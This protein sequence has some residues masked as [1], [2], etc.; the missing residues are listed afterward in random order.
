MST[1]IDFSASIPSAAKIKSAGHVGAVMYISPARD[2]WMGAKPVYRSTIDDFDAHGLQAAFVWQFGAGTALA[3]DV[4]RGWDGGVADAKAAQEHLTSIRCAGHP[5]FFA[6]DFDISLIQWN[7]IAAQYF[8]GAASVLG[9]QRVGIYGHSRVIHW[10]MEDDVVA[11]VE[12]GRVLGWQTRSW[13][14]GVIARDY[15]VLYQRIHN[16][17]GPD[18]VQIDVN[19]VLYPEWG[20]RALD[21]YQRPA[22]D[23]DNLPRVDKTRWMNK[24]Y[25]PGRSGRTIKKI[26]RHHMAGIGDVDTC[27]NW[28][29]SR[30]A[31]AHYAVQDDHVG[32][33]VRDEDTAWSNAN[34]VS[35]QESITIE[36]SNSAGAASDWPISD[37]TIHRGAE[38]AAE[39]CLKHNLGR[40]QYGVN[41]DD[42]RDHF[43]TSCPHHL[44]AGGKYHDQWMSHAQAH[45]DALT[46]VTVTASEP[47]FL[48][49]LMSQQVKS[50]INP[51]KSF[52]AATALGLID[53]S[54]WRQEVLGEALLHALGLDVE[55]ILAAAIEAD[56]TGGNRT[57][58]IR[59]ALNLKEQ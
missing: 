40:P 56:N 35:N 24:H 37:A 22:V 55:G 51:E 38:L 25:T 32:Q 14:S 13:S 49:E 9:K 27:W 53:A 23:V 19:D 29:Q 31:S 57:Q 6:V 21:S 17:P 7:N 20:W 58:A 44:A 10:A 47:T 3:S 36:H 54:S 30:A 16:A 4:M 45:Y 2:E 1:V 8:K 26:T 50:F 28:W 34:S 5:V 18:G 52:P 33:L 41:I 43:A 42:H 11:T 48:E 46:S 39:L 59:R 12:P 15:A